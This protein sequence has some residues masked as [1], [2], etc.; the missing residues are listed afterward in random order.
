MNLIVDFVFTIWGFFFKIPNVFLKHK[1]D[2]Q[3]KPDKTLA[4]TQVKLIGKWAKQEFHLQTTGFE[5]GTFFSW[6]PRM[7]YTC[8]P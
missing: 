6:A 5:P 2:K 3:T 1:Q 8:E 7:G 4:N